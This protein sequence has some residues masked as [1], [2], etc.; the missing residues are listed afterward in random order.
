MWLVRSRYMF[1]KYYYWDFYI[2]K[3]MYKIFDSC[4]V[5][6]VFQSVFYLE[7]Y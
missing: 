1:G 7:M 5:V 6:V 3:N 2:A 4:M